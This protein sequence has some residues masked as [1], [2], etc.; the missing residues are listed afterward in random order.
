MKAKT[1][2]RIFFILTTFIIVSSCEEKSTYYTE[3]EEGVDNFTC[4]FC[5]GYGCYLCSNGS[6]YSV[7]EIE[8]TYE[9]KGSNV[10]FRGSKTAYYA[11]CSHCSCKLYIP[12]SGG[13]SYCATCLANNHTHSLKSAHVKRYK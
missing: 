6:V 10:S 2:I 11:E 4:P 9:K 12:I 8:R 1:V 7:V 13:D 3:T 5:N